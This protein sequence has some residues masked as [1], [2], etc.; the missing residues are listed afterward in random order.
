MTES[1]NGPRTCGARIRVNNHLD[2]LLYAERRDAPGLARRTVTCALAEHDE[3]RH[4]GVA[5][6][7]VIPEGGAVWA[8]W[9]DGEKPSC[10]AHE[11]CGKP[12]PDPHEPCNLFTA[13]PGPCSFH[14]D[15]LREDPL[16]TG[17][18]DAAL[19][20]LVNLGWHDEPTLQAAA[21]DATLLTWD[22]LRARGIWANLPECDHAAVY[23]LLSRCGSGQALRPATA[24]ALARDVVEV[25]R[26]WAPSSDGRLAHG[27]DAEALLKDLEALSPEWQA[28]VLGGQ[29]QPVKPLSSNLFDSEPPARSPRTPLAEVLRGAVQLAEAGQSPPP[30]SE[31][32]WSADWDR[33][34]DRRLGADMAGRLS[35][36]PYGWRADT[37]RRIAAGA[38]AL[39]AVSDAGQ[40]INLIRS[41]G[42]F[43][44]WNAQPRS[45][46]PSP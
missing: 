27:D 16:R 46:H 28:L 5:R 17:R 26:L 43:V 3:K 15:T 8:S 35:K 18:I 10:L 36:L 14:L 45:P 32:S 33:K 11:N 9:A 21:H 44:A 1:A 41:A 37:I 29:R 31:R 22:E 42:I 40:A 20:V 19:D 24:E 30:P 13:H 23:R 6:R 7:L 2:Q 34:E 39:D 25:T 4:Q 38:T 12:G